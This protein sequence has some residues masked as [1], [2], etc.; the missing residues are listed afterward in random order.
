VAPVADLLSRLPVAERIVFGVLAR[1]GRWVFRLPVVGRILVVALM[2][3]GFFFV[4]WLV[5]LLGT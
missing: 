4:A 3:V 5:L 2:L 1:L